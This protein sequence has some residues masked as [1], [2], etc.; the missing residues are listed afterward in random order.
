[1]V[2]KNLF[3]TDFRGI[4]LITKFKKESEGGGLRNTHRQDH[5]TRKLQNP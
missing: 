2:N 5:F 4:L 1:M 3:I